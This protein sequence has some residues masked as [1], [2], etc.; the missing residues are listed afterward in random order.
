MRRGRDRRAGKAKR[1]PVAT[2]QGGGQLAGMPD[3]ASKA[4]GS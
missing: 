2:T 4:V 1:K 3:W